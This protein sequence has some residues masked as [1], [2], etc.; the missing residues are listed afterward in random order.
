MASD[1]ITSTVV[2]VTLSLGFRCYYYDWFIYVFVVVINVG[3]EF[4]LLLIFFIL[5]ASDHHVT[6]V[7]IPQT[8]TFVHP[9]K[10]NGS[11]Y[12]TMPVWRALEVRVG[13]GDKYTPTHT[14]TP[15]HIHTQ[16]VHIHTH[17]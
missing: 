12:L 16:K 7:P 10:V 15:K 8:H 11:V 14:D 3:V 4:H 13:G 6:P 1:G 17:T 5:Y 9:T 2:I